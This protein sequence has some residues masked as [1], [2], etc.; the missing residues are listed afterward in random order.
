MLFKIINLANNVII[1]S[2]LHVFFG[3]TII[4]TGLKLCCMAEGGAKI[5]E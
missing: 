4:L 1:E 2:Y 5:I 3:N